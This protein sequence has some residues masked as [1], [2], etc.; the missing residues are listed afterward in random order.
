MNLHFLWGTL[1]VA[2]EAGHIVL[3]SLTGLIIQ[4][5]ARC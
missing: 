5:T 2:Y 1:T 3:L 4:D